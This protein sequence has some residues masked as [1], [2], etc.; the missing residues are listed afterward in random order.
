MDLT[1]R[2]EGRLGTS[3]PVYMLSRAGGIDGETAG[4]LAVVFRWAEGALRVMQRARVNMVTV[5]S[6][7]SKGALFPGAITL[8]FGNLF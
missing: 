5:A 2:A 8:M 6:N 4:A 7:D 3:C 1:G